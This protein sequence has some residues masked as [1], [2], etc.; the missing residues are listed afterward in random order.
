M[1]Y[2][3]IMPYVKRIR[4]FE[5]TLRS[6]DWHYRFRND[7]ELVVVEDSKNIEDKKEHKMLVDMI[8]YYQQSFPIIHLEIKQKVYNPAPLY[9]AGW[10]LERVVS[11]I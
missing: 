4:Q 9:N 8:G 6:F 7:F 2:S 3:I 5:R 11:F 1:K 10:R